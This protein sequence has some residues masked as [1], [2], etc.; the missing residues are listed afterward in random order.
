MAQWT[1]PRMEQRSHSKE[2]GET[3]VAAAAVPVVE[4]A[5]V[6]AIESAAGTGETAEEA[7]PE[8]VAAEQIKSLPLS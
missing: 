3:T 5:A 2:L 4:S 6:P 1:N 7:D 8:T